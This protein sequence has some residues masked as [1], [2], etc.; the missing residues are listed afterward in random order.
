MSLEYTVYAYSPSLNQTL[1]QFNLDG[2]VNNPHLTE[3]QA[4]QWAT[5][6]AAQLNQ[7]TNMGATD[8]QAVVKYEELGIQTLPGY[9]FHN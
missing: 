2:G 3:E 1:R 8:W 5:G 9:L 4:N 6:F 7:Q